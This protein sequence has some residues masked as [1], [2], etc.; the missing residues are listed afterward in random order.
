MKKIKFTRNLK[1]FND[2]ISKNLKQNKKTVL[3]SMSSKLTQEYKNK[4]KEEGYNVVCH[5]GI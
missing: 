3:P 2:E 1:H 5:N 4:Y